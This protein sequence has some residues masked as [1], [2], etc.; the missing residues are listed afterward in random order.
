MQGE[1]DRTYAPVTDFSSI[2]TVLTIA[3]TKAYCILQMDV[4]TAFLH[5]KIDDEVY[6]SPPKEVSINVGKRD[7]LRLRKG[8]YGL[9]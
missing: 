5:G 8:I 1:I 6:V 9:Q 3:M 7:V 4:K 2:R